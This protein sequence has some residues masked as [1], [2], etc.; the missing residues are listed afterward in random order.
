MKSIDLD[1]I[2]FNRN[3]FL[4]NV[5]LYPAEKLGG[6]LYTEIK[7][8]PF[9][10]HSISVDV[11]DYSRIDTTFRGPNYRGFFGVIDKMAFE[12]GQ[13]QILAMTSNDDVPKPAML[14]LYRAYGDF[15][16]IIVH[17]D[18]P[19]NTDALRLFNLK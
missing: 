13:G 9:F 6:G 8:G 11:D 3:V 1:S 4:S 5:H 19:F 18:K 15:Y 12:N 14:V 10:R 2:Q 16:M 17:S 7:F